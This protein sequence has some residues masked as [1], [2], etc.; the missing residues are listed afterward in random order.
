MYCS[1]FFYFGTNI[2]NLRSN[3][4]NPE[5]NSLSLR[6]HYNQCFLCFVFSS[7]RAVSMYTG[8]KAASQHAVGAT[9]NHTEDYSKSG[10]PADLTM[11]LE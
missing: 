8:A 6:V 1:D 9:F 11:S 3:F 10:M 4:F 7:G 2:F 5:S